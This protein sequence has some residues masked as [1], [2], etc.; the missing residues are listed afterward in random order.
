MEENS[1]MLTESGD[2]RGMIDEINP[3]DLVDEV[4]VEVIWSELDGRIDREQV[5]E[6]AL[7]IAQ[8]FTDATVTA[9]VPLFIRRRTFERLK[10]LID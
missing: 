8:E 9:F 1:L 6:T 7:I 5:R 3:A 10:L 2:N 4:L